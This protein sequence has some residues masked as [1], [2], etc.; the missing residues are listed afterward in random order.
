MADGGWRKSEEARTGLVGICG[1]AGAAVHVESLSEIPVLEQGVHRLSFT[2]VTITRIDAASEARRRFTGRWRMFLTPP[3]SGAVNMAMDHALMQRARRTGE[4]VLRVYTWS[5]PTLSLGRHQAARGRI[6]A[7]VAKDLGVSL[8]RRP[9]GGRALLHHREVTYSVTAALERDDSV[10]D[11]YESINLVLLHAL[12]LMGVKAESARP[13]S[14]TPIP[15]SA[16]CFIRADE[17]EIAVSGRKLVG[18]ALLR[19]DG[20]LLQ[21]GSILLD[22]DQF[23]LTDLLPGGEAPSAPPGTLRQALGRV[24]EVEEVANV[25]FAALRASGVEDA[26]PLDDEPLLQVEASEAETI[27]GSEEWTF[28]N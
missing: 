27:Y 17:G 9:T 3:R 28:R 18:S 13:T 16:S 21:H 24:P 12:R 20:A 10:R 15:G 1:Q 22:D 8:V 2:E 19:Q 7:E 5:E 26:T 25:L 14:R 4:R 6:S 11:W 23:L